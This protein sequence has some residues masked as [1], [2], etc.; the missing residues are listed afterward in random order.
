[1]GRWK[2]CGRHPTTGRR[3]EGM[4][5]GMGEL[6]DSAKPNEAQAVRSGPLSHRNGKFTSGSNRNTTRQYGIDNLHITYVKGTGNS[7]DSPS[8][9]NRLLPHLVSEYY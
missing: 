3:F 4:V 5:L 8:I 9:R 2:N 7:F 6:G 1:M